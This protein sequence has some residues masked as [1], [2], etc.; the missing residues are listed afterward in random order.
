[1]EVQDVGLLKPDKAWYKRW[2]AIVLFT[3]LGLMI[4]ITP[5]F[6]FH[7]YKIYQEIKLG[8]YISIDTFKEEAP[9]NMDYLADQMAPS[10]GNPEAKIR[11]VEFGDFNCHLCLQ[12][13]A[14]VKRIIEEYSDDI[15]FYW[16][17][18]PVINESSIDL[19][20]GA[21]CA[22]QQGKFW[23]YHDLVFA[24]QGKINLNNFS[25]YIVIIGLDVDEFNDCLDNN[26]TMAQVRKDYFASE[27]GEVQGTPT[28][29]V[30]GF[31]LQGVMPYETWQDIITKF[32]SVYDS[33]NGN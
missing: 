11:I 31:K 1:M 8:T 10:K 6:L 7:F 22:D 3:I 2:W 28:F 14:T 5:F 17:N 19:A 15:V 27:T 21:V 26:L 4:I 23:E 12:S 24:N 13:S 16:R 18:F 30:N 29:F 25:N 33:N 32:K 20:K 9:Y